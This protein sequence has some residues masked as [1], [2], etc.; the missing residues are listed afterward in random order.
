MR[1]FVDNLF[2]SGHMIS[3]KCIWWQIFVEFL[4]SWFDTINEIHEYWYTTNN[5]NS[6]YLHFIFL[7]SSG[8][9]NIQ[10]N[11]DKSFP[12]IPQS[13]HCS[14]R[15]S[16]NKCVLPITNTANEQYKKMLKYKIIQ[17][18]AIT[19]ISDNSNIRI[20]RN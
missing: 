11:Q 6:Q 10:S 7:W 1:K 12:W 5:N 8:S 17:I 13:K 15:S 14:V 18:Q 3:T 9:S 4:I 2:Q 19:C 16:L 20:F